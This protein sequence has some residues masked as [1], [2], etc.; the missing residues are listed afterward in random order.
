MLRPW[1][2]LRQFP[3]DYPSASLVALF[4]SWK[5]LLLTIAF[6]APGHGY[7]SSTQLFF[8]SNDDGAG[9]ALDLDSVAPHLATKL[10][11]WDAIYLT[12]AALNGYVHEQEWAFSWGFTRLVKLASSGKCFWY[13]MRENALLKRSSTN[14]RPSPAQCRLSWPC[15]LELVPSTLGNGS[16]STCLCFGLVQEPEAVSFFNGSTACPFSCGHIPH[17]AVLRVYFCLGQFSWTVLL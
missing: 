6:L 7:D 9:T 15:H 11:R 4:V 1:D 8:R 2:A 16:F 17:G 5:L 13:A 14:L 12:S 3:L 10:V